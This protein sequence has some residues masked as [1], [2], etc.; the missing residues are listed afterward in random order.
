MP[1]SKFYAG[2]IST[3]PAFDDLFAKER[4]QMLAPVFGRDAAR[5]AAH[6]P[7]EKRWIR[8]GDA[9]AAERDLRL[10]RTIRLST[11]IIVKAW[12]WTP[13][14]SLAKMASLS[15]RTWR[16]V[17]GRKPARDN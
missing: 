2:G 6:P 14:P 1:V 15:V 10:A 5:C 7:L 12:K 11:T 13:L 9:M 3:N 4:E 17:F 8:E 16:R